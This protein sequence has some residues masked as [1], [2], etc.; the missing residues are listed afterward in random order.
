M[1]FR[2]LASRHDF[3]NGSGSKKLTLSRTRPLWPSS[4]TWAR[5]WI[6]DAQGQKAKSPAGGVRVGTPGYHHCNRGYHRGPYVERRMY[7]ETIAEQ[8]MREAAKQ[9]GDNP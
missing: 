1:C 3:R 7:R 6:S 4:P 8:R 5:T 9:M 2:L